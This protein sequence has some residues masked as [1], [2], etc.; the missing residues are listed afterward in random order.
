MG[1]HL[2]HQAWPTLTLVVILF[3]G[4]RLRTDRSFYDNFRTFEFTSRL[5]I[6]SVI[7][8]AERYLSTPR[9]ILRP[10]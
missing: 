1:S 7:I 3:V 4:P 6:I 10:N 2:S 8:L 9:I 5:I